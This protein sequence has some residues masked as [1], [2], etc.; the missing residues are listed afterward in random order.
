MLQRSLLLH[1]GSA[2]QLKRNMEYLPTP[3][4]NQ[5]IIESCFI[6][7][8]ML[9]PVLLL[10]S[11]ES[12]I[13]FGKVYLSIAFNNKHGID[14][15]NNSVFIYLQPTC[16]QTSKQPANQQTKQLPTYLPCIKVRIN[17]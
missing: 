7:N 3:S 1:S 8:T 16:Q 4:I 17:V 14:L 12:A 5:T 10:D 13:V 6:I 11:Q 15:S 2:V 9:R